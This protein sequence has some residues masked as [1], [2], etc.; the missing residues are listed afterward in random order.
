MKFSAN[1][2]LL[3]AMIILNTS[4]EKEINLN[5]KDVSPKLVVEGEVL[6]GK[7]T[8]INEQKIK[9]S[10]S[11]NYLGRSF[12]EPVTNAVV[13]VTDGVNTYPYA[14]ISNGV[15]KSIFTASAN[16]TYQLT[17][18]Y[19]NDVYVANEV[20]RD[21]GA[22]I[23]DLSVNFIPGAFGD[24]GG[25]FLTLNT[26]DPENEKNFYLWR[27]YINNKFM[28]TATPG[29]RRSTIQTDEFFNG[30]KL[31]DYLPS[32]EFPVEAGDT[33]EMQQLNISEQ[34]Y[35][36]YYSIF[37][38]TAASSVTGDVPPG[39]ILGNIINTTNSKKS[40][41]GYFGACSISIKRKYIK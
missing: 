9:L 35:N 30:Q 37:T 40:A 6:L 29:N 25:N 34:M 23:D 13:E 1:L 19:G 3:S 26:K 21:G 41:L 22:K 24:P 4:C 38:L 17:I 10:L 32:D 8:L 14:H 16:K 20:L 36:F 18:K 7:D 33:A 2:F 28:M 27:L 39:K 12:P 31:V 5:L 15:Y 11:A